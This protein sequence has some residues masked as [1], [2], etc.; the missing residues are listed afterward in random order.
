MSDLSQ[1][2]LPNGNV[3]DLKDA[4]ARKDI[5]TLKEFAASGVSYEGVTTTA[6]TDGSTVTSITISENGGNKTITAAKGMMVNY[7][8]V[9]YGYNGS[10][11]DQLGSAG[12]LKALAYKDSVS[13]STTPSGDVSKPT[14]TGSPVTVNVKGTPSGSVAA[15][16]FTGKSKSVSVS[17]TPSGD[18]AVTTAKAETGGTS[19]YTPSGEVGVATT[20]KN[21]QQITGVGTL[22]AWSATVEGE[23]L[24]F[25]WNTGTLPTRAAVSVADGIKQAT[26]TGDATNITAKFTGK[27]LTSSGTYQPEGTN[28]APKFTGNELSSSGEITPSGDVS[29]PV[30]T[31]NKDT[32]T[33]K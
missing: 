4:A 17:G 23:K 11:W 14:F 12:E 7:N 19:N 16:V 27:S 22:P 5:A 6:L 28:T 10:E 30:F 21:I 15:P 1:F 26:F 33:S 8:N 3:Y 29:K 25:S 13:G 2:Q 9:M 31:G 32:I 18:V 20:N 24:I